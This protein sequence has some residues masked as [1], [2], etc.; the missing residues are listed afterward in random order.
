MADAATFRIQA[1][2]RAGQIPGPPGRDGTHG[3][4]GRDGDPGPKGPR[5][6]PGPQG[7]PGLTGLTGDSGPQGPQGDPGPQGEQGFQGLQGEPGPQGE[8][9]SQGPQGFEGFPGPPG[10]QGPPGQLG[11]IGPQGP[12]GEKGPQ[13]D[14]GLQG[15]P[16]P[17][18]DPGP[19]GPVGPPRQGI[20]DGSVAPIGQ[21]GEVIRYHRTIPSS[22]IR[23]DGT[24]IQIFTVA[25]TPGDWDTSGSFHVFIYPQDPV[26]VFP[27][28][29]RGMI[30]LSND[31]VGEWA[32]PNKIYAAPGTYQ[33]GPTD[34]R[35]IAIGASL[36]LPRAVLNVP[37]AQ[38]ITFTLAMTILGITIGPTSSIECDFWA[39]RMN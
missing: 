2:H 31:Y 3:A 12:S 1:A 4:H 16:G 19:E 28:G 37:Q 29:G 23:V 39:R 20:T 24:A 13:G 8:Q 25:V 11:P 36:I 34:T 32:L 14:I 6:D 38:I 7:P 5:G 17:Q 18:G 15:P 9:G 27:Y 10:A 26:D 30:M 35:F 22:G 21:V 33:M